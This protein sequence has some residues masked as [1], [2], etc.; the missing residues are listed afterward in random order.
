MTDNHINIR[1]KHPSG[2]ISVSGHR[3]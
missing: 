3:Q 1:P 2:R